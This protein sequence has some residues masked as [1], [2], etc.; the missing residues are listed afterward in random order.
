MLVIDAMHCILEGIVHYHCCHVLRLDASERQA[1]TDGVKYAFDW[2][3]IPY[4]YDSTPDNLK[5]D[6]G[7]LCLGSADSEHV[8]A[9]STFFSELPASYRSK[10]S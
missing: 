9:R 4:N 7:R 8:A 10:H 6:F 1:N 3:W 2:P 5:L